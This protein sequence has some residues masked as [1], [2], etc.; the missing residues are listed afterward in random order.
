[1]NFNKYPDLV[2][3]L[4]FTEITNFPLQIRNISKELNFSKSLGTS[5]I[6][7]FYFMFF[8]MR[9]IQGF[10]LK[11]EVCKHNN[12]RD[13]Y[14]V[15]GIYLLWIYWFCLLNLKIFQVIKSIVL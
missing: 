14:L 2:A 7:I 13:C 6:T 9:V 10:E 3:K 12:T 15:N 8:K 11:N 4:F 5:C 1:M